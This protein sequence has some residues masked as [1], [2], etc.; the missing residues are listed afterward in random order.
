MRSSQY[1]VLRKDNFDGFISRLSRLQK[2]VAPVSK[3]HNNFAF[4]EVTAGYEVAVNYIPTILP[5]KK[6]L[7]PQR[8]T[9]LEFNV[10]KGLESTPVVE[11]EKTTIFGIHTCDIAGIQCLNMVFS[12]RPR[13]FNYLTR[14]ER[15]TI[16][17][18]EC[19]DYCDE[20]AN[21]TLVNANHPHGG[22]DLFFTGM[23]EYF[24]VHVNTQAG[25]EIIAAAK[26]FEDA[27]DEQL[28]ALASLREKKRKIFKN[29][30]PIDPWKITELFDRSFDSKVWDELGERCLACGNCTN[31]CPTCYCF[32]VKDELNL[33]LKSGK[34]YRVWDSCQAEPFA[35]VA[36]N[37]NFRKERADRQKHRYYRKFRYPVDTYHR[38][39]CTGC[40]RCSRT[41]MAGIRLKE[42]LNALIKEQAT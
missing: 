37:H 24:I 15:T 13:D 9:L 8:E 23:G 36:G 28:K 34:R 4:E 18:L 17:G 25:E 20:Y 26:F 12:T 38:L 27:N 6:Y 41:C 40:G 11:H 32:D 22:Y 29:E 19:N 21:C 5:P 35:A 16:I 3:G 42:T 31:V 7:M 30:V 10:S 2:L 33:D 39:F 1:V 14:K